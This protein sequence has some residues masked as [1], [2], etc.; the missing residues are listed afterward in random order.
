MMSELDSVYAIRETRTGVP[1][2]DLAL[3][4]IW[5]DVFLHN[6]CWHIAT[7]FVMDT[8]GRMQWWTE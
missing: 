1:D 7:R 4:A 6:R 2:V 8:T 5:A 3:S